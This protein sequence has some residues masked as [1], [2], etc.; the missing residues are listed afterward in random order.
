MIA[1]E[2]GRRR[3][4]PL[5]YSRPTGCVPFRPTDPCPAVEDVVESAVETYEAARDGDVLGVVEGWAV[6]PPSVCGVR[7]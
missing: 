2:K 5:P 4:V 7:E 3:E 1:A 6:W